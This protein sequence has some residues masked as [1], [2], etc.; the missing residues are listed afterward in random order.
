MKDST[1]VEITV[2]NKPMRIETGSLARQAKGAVTVQMADTM[3]FSAVSAADAP[4]EGIDYFPLQVE[5]REKF[6]AAGQFPGG[7]F[8]RE[9][10]PSEKETLT[11]RFTDRPIRPLF[12]KG[13]NNEV[14]I[15]NMLLSADGENDGDILSIV[16]SSAAL[17]VSDLP[18]YGPIASVRVGRID[19]RFIIN[20]TN[21]ERDQSD[22]DLIYVCNADL[23]VMIEG[24]AREIKEPDL[25]AAMR[26]GHEEC[27]KIIAE[28]W[29]LR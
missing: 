23:P 7:F 14:Q 24:N 1:F 20:P 21:A 13:Y 16:A 15:N 12:Q 22:L 28:P 6:Y 18:F 19:G 3:V 17:V 5:Y 4:R 8:K 25:L 11:A 2:G 29:T 27:M 10:R 26:A 9:A